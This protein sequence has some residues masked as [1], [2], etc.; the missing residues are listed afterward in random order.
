MTE[1]RLALSLEAIRAMGEGAELV[2]DIPDGDEVMRVM[3]RCDDAALETI[4]ERVQR[5]M[6][7]FLP[8]DPNVH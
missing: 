2:F 1:L 7:H 3:L 6:L 8:P 5:A 4:R